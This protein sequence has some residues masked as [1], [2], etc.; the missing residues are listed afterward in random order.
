MSSR[1]TEDTA[2]G[3]PQLIAAVGVRVARVDVLLE[4]LNVGHGR[5]AEGAG[6]GQLGRTWLADAMHPTQ[7]APQV[8]LAADDHVADLAGEA[9]P[10]GDMDEL[11]TLERTPRPQLQLAREARP[12]AT[13]FSQAKHLPPRA[14]VFEEREAHEAGGREK[15]REKPRCGSLHDTMRAINTSPSFYLLPSR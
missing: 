8:V 3:D 11:V 12:A 9:L 6:Q 10:E 14:K 5:E 4:V 13:A 15:E 2:G 1:C 7:M